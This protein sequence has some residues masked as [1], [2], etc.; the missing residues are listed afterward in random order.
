MLDKFDLKSR[1]DGAT[2][3]SK[4]PADPI[5]FA[6]SIVYPQINGKCHQGKTTPLRTG[7]CCYFPFVTKPTCVV[8]V[9]EIF[10]QTVLTLQLWID[11]S[12]SVTVFV[13]Y[14]PFTDLT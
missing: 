14:L 2:I 5:S 6:L 3:L 11:I 13:G 8:R 9:G 1:E 4:S 12:V 10:Q 7:K